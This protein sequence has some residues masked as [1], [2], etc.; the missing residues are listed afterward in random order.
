MIIE[1]TRYDMTRDFT[2]KKF[3]KAVADGYVDEML[4][5]YLKKYNENLKGTYT[6]SSCA[7]RILVLGLDEEEQKKP[8]L[9]VGKWHRTVKLKE[10]VE[11]LDETK[12]DELWLK[13]EPFII[14][15]VVKDLKGAERVLNS[16]KIAGIKRGGI[17][18]LKEGRI[19]IEV[20]GTGYMSV[21]VKMRGKILFNKKQLGILI[22]KANAKV[23][24]NYKQLWKFLNVLYKEMRKK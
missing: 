11:K 1:D 17:I 16:K 19:I 7:G 12:F 23:K 4:V 15:I 22:K 8:N 5:P 13:Q 24:R 21:P 9:F 18:N 10:V 3:Y 2:L 14:H 6:T 20:L